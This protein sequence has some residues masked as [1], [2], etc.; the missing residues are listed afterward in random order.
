MLPQCAFGQ[1]TWAWPDASQGAQSCCNYQLV[2]QISTSSQAQDYLA[3]NLW[4]CFICNASKAPKTASTRG[5]IVFHDAGGNMVKCLDTQ[6]YAHLLKWRLTL[7]IVWRFQSGIF[8][9]YLRCL[10]NMYLI[11]HLIHR[12]DPSLGWLN[13][14]ED[15]VTNEQ[16]STMTCRSI[17]FFHVFAVFFVLVLKA[18]FRHTWLRND[19]NIDLH[20]VHYLF[21]SQARPKDCMAGAD[22][23]W[24]NKFATICTFDCHSFRQSPRTPTQLLHLCTHATAIDRVQTPTQATQNSTECNWDVSSKLGR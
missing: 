11:V 6:W 1:L 15:E 5:W 23:F 24:K 17:S 20:T 19:R 4:F 13:S 7:P 10:R 12:I 2:E 18:R 16:T 3:C 22:E 21:T 9:M 14:T 8:A